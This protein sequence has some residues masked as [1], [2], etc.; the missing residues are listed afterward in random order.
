MKSTELTPFAPSF[1]ESSRA[2]GYSL[3]A[4]VSDIIDNSITAKA[5]NIEVNFFPEH[6]DGPYIY[7]LDDGCGMTEPVLEEAMR[8]GSRSPTEVRAE[9]DLG[10]YGLGM[11]TASLSQCRKMTVLT[12]SGGKMSGR[13]WDLDFVL[14][15]KTW[16][17]LILEEEDMRLVPG[18]DKLVNQDQGTIVVWQNLDRLFAGDLDPKN[19]LGKKMDILRDHLSLVFHR[20]IAGEQGIRKTRISLNNRPVI[21]TDPF[22]SGKSTQTFDDEIIR[23]ENSEIVVRPYTLPHLSKLTKEEIDS[24]GG[25]DGL[26]K[27]QGFYVY[28][29]K[30]LLIWGE[31]FR[32][33]RKGELSKLARIRVDIPNSLDDLWV[34]DIKKSTATPPEVVRRNLAH[35]IDKVAA[36]SKR[37]WTYRG[38]KEQEK[39]ETKIWN[40]LLTRDKSVMYEINAEHPIIS[41]FIEQHPETKRQLL[42]ILKQIQLNLPLN[43][44]YVDLTNDEK[45]DNDSEST[46]EEILLTIRNMIQT[47]PT[48]DLKLMYIDAL[49]KTEPFDAFEDRIDE[50][51]AKGGLP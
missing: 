29:N 12:K 28:R 18:Y 22:L 23:I 41:G 30:R 45:I 27:G 10:R 1:M 11:K 17:L 48:R 7:I 46:A 24:L 35:F 25:K 3:E 40:R 31:W 20:Y 15:K 16:S 9:D 14:K 26:R 8:Y 36:E 49:K 38:K 39:P 5:E 19:A 44:L 50:E 42:S 37:K 4:A 21:P 32:L 13:S 6:S 34:L 51:I 47:L 2:I 33:M 43:Q